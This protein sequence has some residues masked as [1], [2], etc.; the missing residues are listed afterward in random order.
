M[1]QIDYV[2]YLRLTLV[3]QSNMKTYKD[4]DQQ[5]PEWDYIRKGKITGTGLKKLN[6]T[7]K[8][9]SEYFYEVIA[10]RLT[11]GVE[12]GH[13]NPMDRGNRL[14]PR[15]REMFE[16]AYNLDV[17]QI[18]FCESDDSN[19]MG[20]SPDGLI[21]NE[22]GIYSEDIE[23]KCPE[24][25]NYVKAWLTNVVPEE[26][27]EQNIQAFII[28]KDLQKRYFILF[29]PEITIHPMHVIEVT[30]E[31]LGSEVELLRTKQVSFINE[32]NAE[33]SNLL[34]KYEETINI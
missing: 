19:F 6:G 17:E 12:E 2:Y 31:S 30:R 27:H 7:P 14:E 25:R 9:R 28:N 15:A 22:A 26:Y 20:Y 18:G 10:E 3:V 34:E 4:I 8:A 21:A 33:I 5:T 1:R 29:N 16:F 11:D 23:I 24:G 13:E 32:V